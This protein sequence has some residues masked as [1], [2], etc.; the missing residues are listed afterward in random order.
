MKVH[1]STIPTVLAILGIMSMVFLQT[2]RAKPMNTASEDQPNSLP[3]IP[4]LAQLGEQYNYFF[5]IEVA[6]KD[7]EVKSGIDSR[8]IQR[9]SGKNDLQQELEQLRLAIPN[10]SYEVDKANP[11]IIHVK[12]A[13]LT[14]YK[15]YAL[16]SI[17][18]SINFTGKVNDL[19]SEISKQGIP[20]SPPPV[21]SFEES[22][23]YTTV[24]QVK[25]AGLKVRDALSYFLPL[26][27]RQSRILWIASTKLG[28]GQMTYLYYPW[29]GKKP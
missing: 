7:T 29:P 21:M 26:E 9:R 16:E 5:T 19:P 11:R 3:L 13:R 15:G 10:F 25:G 4:Y 2:Q 8:W 24:V 27:K 17:I 22:R 6:S 20:L 28:Q 18:K 1:K 14:E 12:D 23:D